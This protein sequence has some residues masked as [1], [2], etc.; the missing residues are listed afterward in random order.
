MKTAII[1]GSSR[2]IGAAI[3]QR[4][5]KDGLAVV[6]NYANDKSNAD[7]LVKKIQLDG[8]KAVA[9]QADVRDSQSV[10]ALFDVTE[11]EFGPVDILINNAGIMKLSPV[12]KSS[13]ELFTE[14]IDINLRGTFNCLREAATR[15]RDGGR[16]IN[17]STSVVGLYQPTYGV[18]AATKSAVETLT[19]IL[20]KELGAKRINVNCVAPGPTATELFLKDKTEADI[21]PI[22]GRTPLGRL[23]D[24][25]D[26][27]NVVS[28]LTGP[29]AAWITG[30]I[31]R[32]NGGII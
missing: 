4:L 31:L 23:G 22:I 12:A 21:A 5:A 27:A 28:F 3:A 6:I 32:V 2:G 8:G 19:H 18:Y 9:A 11:K 20:A 14:T 13:D 30:Q 29:D 7:N 1:T 16:I 25:N 24:V 15:L 10:K 26:I 17:F